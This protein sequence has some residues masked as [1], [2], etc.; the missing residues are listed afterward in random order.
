MQVW[1]EQPFMSKQHKTAL[2]NCVSSET[3]QLP[4]SLRSSLEADTTLQRQD[5]L[6]LVDIIKPPES[7]EAN[8]TEDTFRKRAWGAFPKDIDYRP[9]LVFIPYSCK[10]Y[11]QLCY[12]EYFKFHKGE[13][14]S[15]IYYVVNR[16]PFYQSHNSDIQ[17]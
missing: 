1:F 4:G 15:N 16:S 14:M 17:F 12:P 2:I 10:R 8:A 6:S 11:S 3:F 13:T 9:L 7:S 5:S